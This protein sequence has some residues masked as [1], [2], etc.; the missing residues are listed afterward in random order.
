VGQL[1]ARPLI[2][3]YHGVDAGWDSPLAVSE[4]DLA[5]HAAEL[6][7]RGFAGLTL[8]ES[9]HR[10]AAGTLPERSV[11]FTFD[12]GYE[13]VRRAARIL[14]HHG[15]P[16]TVFVVT[17]YVGSA[18]PMSWF[19]VEHEPPERMH[20]LDWD[21]LQ[22]L[23]GAGWEVGSHTLN[24]PLTT[25]LTDA[26]LEQQLAG[27]RRAIEHRLGACSS[28]SYPYGAADRRVAEA[29]AR[30]GYTV[31]CTLTGAELED[32]PLLRPRVG[33]AARDRGV[34]LRLKTSAPGLRLRR[35]RAARLL[36]RARRRRSWMPSSSAVL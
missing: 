13:S 31:A 14:A 25:A 15:F 16:G 19:G 22:E 1:P 12:D 6:R 35:T 24:H 32:E 17:D 2:L 30:A 26:E 23:R 20:S 27:S 21:E 4:Q 28:L 34:R 29:A 18:T 11:V 7:D 10:R 3:A 9:E 33:M 5:A 36:R 8:T